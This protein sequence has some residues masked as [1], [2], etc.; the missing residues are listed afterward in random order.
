M[1]DNSE[2]LVEPGTECGSRGVVRSIG[3]IVNDPEYPSHLFALTAGFPIFGSDGSFADEGVSLGEEAIGDILVRPPKQHTGYER[4]DSDVYCASSLIQF[5]RLRQDTFFEILPSDNLSAL[6][7]QSSGHFKTYDGNIPPGVPGFL[8]SHRS[9]IPLGT[10]AQQRSFFRMPMSPESSPTS[11]HN[12][13]E[14]SVGSEDHVPIPGQQGGL[15]VDREDRVLGILIGTTGQ[16]TFVAPFSDL[17]RRHELRPVNREHLLERKAAITAAISLAE[18]GQVNRTLSPIDRDVV[19][20]MQ[21]NSELLQLRG[22]LVEH[23]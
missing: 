12:A 21:E 11:F 17:T 5:V 18:S 23:D 3:L 15:V 20:T 6:T 10:L 4:L 14:I 8:Y 13:I 22:E 2:T 16:R 9:K 19:S 1:S 7:D